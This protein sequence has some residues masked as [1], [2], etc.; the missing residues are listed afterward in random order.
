MREGG[1]KKTI[2][3][4]LSIN[5]IEVCSRKNK[6]MNTKIPMIGQI[7]PPRSAHI[8]SQSPSSLPHQ[9]IPQNIPINGRLHFLLPLLLHSL[10]PL[11]HFHCLNFLHPQIPR[12]P[13][14]QT[15]ISPIHHPDPPTNSSGSGQSHSGSRRLA[16]VGRL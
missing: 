1:R 15:S 10:S 16:N 7:R 8:N 11:L 14:H 3:E 4:L 13:C 6:M 12:S 9:Q 2:I 5:N